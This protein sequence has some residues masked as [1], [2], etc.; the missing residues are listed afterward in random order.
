MPKRMLTVLFLPTLQCVFQLCFEF[1]LWANQV[2]EESDTDDTRN[3]C[4]TRCIS[5]L[6]LFTTAHANA[7]NTKRSWENNLAVHQ[8]SDKMDLKHST[9]SLCHNVL[10]IGISYVQ[11]ISEQVV[12]ACNFWSYHNNSTAF[13][14]S[15]LF[16]EKK[17]SCLRFPAITYCPDLNYD[18]H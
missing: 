3:L 17:C 14:P 1:Q 7:F 11:E 15:S 13:I 9:C 12:S 2:G 18:Q 5:V 10:N 4:G 16:Q 8:E 6:V